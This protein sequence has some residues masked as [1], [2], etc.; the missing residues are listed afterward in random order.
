MSECII[1]SYEFDAFSLRAPCS[2]QV[3]IEQWKVIHLF[4][5]VDRAPCY[6]LF[7]FML[8]C[9]TVSLRDYL[10]NKTNYVN[11][12]VRIIVNLIG[13]KREKYQYGMTVVHTLPHAASHMP[14]RVK[15]SYS[16]KYS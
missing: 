6:R 15:Y 2:M 4:W 9:C 11:C 5:S 16:T 1:C 12:I 7:S 8:V 14:H 10:I 3:G 13:A